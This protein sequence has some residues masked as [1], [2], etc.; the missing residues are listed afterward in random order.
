MPTRKQEATEYLN[1]EFPRKIKEKLTKN[2]A[3]SHVSHGQY[4]HVSGNMWNQRII[5]KLLFMVSALNAI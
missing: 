2:A 3:K 4:G 5:I 1:G